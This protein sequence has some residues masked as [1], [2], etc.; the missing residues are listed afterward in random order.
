[1]SRPVALRGQGCGADPTEL[2]KNDNVFGLLPV[3]AGLKVAV[4]LM[5]VHQVGG[6]PQLQ[7]RRHLGGHASTAE[8]TFCVQFVAFALY[9]TPLLYMFEKLVGV[10]EKALWIRLPCRLPV[11]ELLLILHAAS[12]RTASQCKSD[13]GV[14]CALQPSS[15][16]CWA[17]CCRSTAQVS[18]AAERRGPS[19]GCFEAGGLHVTKSWPLCAVNAFMGAFGAPLIA[20]VLPALAFNWVFR[21]QARRDACV[22]PPTRQPA[23]PPPLANSTSAWLNPGRSPAPSAAGPSPCSTG[24]WPS[25]ST[26]SSLLSSWDSAGERCVFCDS[27]GLQEGSPL[28]SH[29]SSDWR[30]RCTTPSRASSTTPTRLAFLQ[31]T[32]HV[33]RPVCFCYPPVRGGPHIPTVQSATSARPTTRHT[34]AEG[35][36]MV[37]TS[38]CNPFSSREA[39]CS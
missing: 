34:S 35:N 17:S 13:R 33:S 30:C 23:L 24:T 2:A 10:H 4:W 31:V 15:S 6:A 5:V 29:C 28:V 16:T 36:I 32:T 20:F 8:S 38:G 14:A 21:G 25:C 26:P 18:P 1:M 9:C 7:A 27:L 19:E 22:Y 37:P 11:G 12:T 39:S 3:D